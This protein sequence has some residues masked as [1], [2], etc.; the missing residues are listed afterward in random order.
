MWIEL[1]HKKAAQGKAR[2]ILP[3]GDDERIRNAAASA[4]G[5]KLAEI[6]VMGDTPVD[7]CHLVKPVRNRISHS[8]KLVSRGKYDGIVLGAVTNTA[9]VIKEALKNIGAKKNSL[10]SS[11]FLMQTDKKQMGEKGAFLFADCA[12]IPSPD[13]FALAR[14]ATDTAH[15]AR[16]I[17]SWSPRVAFLSFSTKG[18]A[19][20][21]KIT[22]IRLAMDELRRLSPD[23]DY[24]GELQLDAA[25]IPEV[26]EKKDPQG[27][28]GG[29]ANILVFPD[30]N[31]A[32]IGY[33]LTER[34]A[35]AKAIGP[36]MQGFKKPVNDL[37][38]G[39]SVEDIMNVI[40]FTAAQAN[41]S[42]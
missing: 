10:V 36:I 23:F 29:R 15:N 8:M 40:A 30:L 16:D 2:L 38:R 1:I 39:S 22:K 6:G 19:E 9:K 3:E 13:P 28:L 25:V 34:M 35:G 26:A 42:K 14:I 27:K 32:N 7:N 4:A 33:K 31:A 18:S 21:D 24:D 12:V 11:F 17:L 37:S 5:K 20:H 41:K